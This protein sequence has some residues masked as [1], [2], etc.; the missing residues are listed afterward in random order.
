MNTGPDTTETRLGT[1]LELRAR[2]EGYPNLRK[3]EDR[4]MVDMGSLGTVD[5]VQGCH[6]KDDATAKVWGN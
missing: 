1:S 3:L 4:W 2:E 6:K 5:T